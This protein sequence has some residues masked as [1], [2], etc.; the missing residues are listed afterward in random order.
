MQQHYLT[1]LLVHSPSYL[2]QERV[3]LRS[4]Q[5][6]QAQLQYVPI[7]TIVSIIFSN[8]RCKIILKGVYWNSNL[9]IGYFFMVNVA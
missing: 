7:L 4:A 8:T 3:D 9:S 6:Y 5:C 1:L 2:Q